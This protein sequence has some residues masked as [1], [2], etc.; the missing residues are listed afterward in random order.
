MV[1][2]SI[3]YTESIPLMPDEDLINKHLVSIYPISSS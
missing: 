1:F 2:S 3:D